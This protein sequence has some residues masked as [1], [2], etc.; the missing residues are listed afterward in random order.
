MFTYFFPPLSCVCVL[1]SGSPDAP[2]ALYQHLHLGRSCAFTRRGQTVRPQHQET[3]PCLSALNSHR[4]E[5]LIN[6]TYIQAYRS[7][8]TSSGA[9]KT[10][11]AL[12]HRVQCSGLW[13]ERRTLLFVYL[14]LEVLFH[15]T[16]CVEEEMLLQTA[17]MLTIW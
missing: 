4:S 11:Y 9:L 12:T 2:S 5:D 6:W 1:F 17:V 3:L 8:T 15:I 10:R 7:R 16:V 14:D 13:D